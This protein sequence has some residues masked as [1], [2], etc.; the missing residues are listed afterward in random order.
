[1]SSYNQRGLSWLPVRF[2]SSS[3]DR[4]IRSGKGQWVGGLAIGSSEQLA[5]NLNASMAP[6]VW[7]LLIVPAF[8][9]CF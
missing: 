9:L 8:L 6:T 7:L 5:M 4:G 1:M 2:L 3:G